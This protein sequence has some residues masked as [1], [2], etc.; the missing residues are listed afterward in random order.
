M[1]EY[2]DLIWELDVC[3]IRGSGLI[4]FVELVFGEYWVVMFVIEE[5]IFKYLIISM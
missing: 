2:W 4:G 1:L 3:C 5:W